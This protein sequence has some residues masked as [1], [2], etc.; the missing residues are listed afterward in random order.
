MSIAIHEKLCPQ[1][2]RC[3]AVSHCPV[4]AL[5]QEGFAAPVVD[6]GKCIDCGKCAEIC[7]MGALISER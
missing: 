6:A 1:N 5:S 3:P 7:P 4:Q 2:H